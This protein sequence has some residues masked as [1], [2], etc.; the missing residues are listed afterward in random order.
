M[1]IFPDFRNRMSAVALGFLLNVLPLC[2][3]CR[4]ADPAA[5]VVLA[6]G[7]WRDGRGTTLVEAVSWEL[8]ASE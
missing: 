7:T 6:A 8:P 5:A 3:V 2:G 4:A 1:G